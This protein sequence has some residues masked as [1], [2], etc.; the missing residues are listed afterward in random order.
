MSSIIKSLQNRETGIKKKLD[1]QKCNWC[2]RCLCRC[3]GCID[4]Q[5]NQEAHY[6]SYDSDGCI[7]DYDSDSD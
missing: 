2:G 3:P 5:P 6:K 7:S 4:E 1:I